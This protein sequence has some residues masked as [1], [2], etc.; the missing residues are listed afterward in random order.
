MYYDISVH[1]L[2]I[3]ILF[4]ILIFSLC[5]IVTYVTCLEKLIIFFILV[6]MFNFDESGL[7]MFKSND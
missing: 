6:S 5:K 2:M 3:F 1:N 4:S 7:Y